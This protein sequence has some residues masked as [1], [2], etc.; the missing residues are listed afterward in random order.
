MGARIQH[1]I[2][3]IPNFMMAALRSR[4]IEHADDGTRACHVPE[5]LVGLTN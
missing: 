2:R 4:V 5:A 3:E 1:Q